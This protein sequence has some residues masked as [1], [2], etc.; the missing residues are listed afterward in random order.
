MAMQVTPVSIHPT[1]KTRAV[2]DLGV[3]SPYL[4]KTHCVRALNLKQNLNKT[5]FDLGHPFEMTLWVS[6]SLNF[7][8][9]GAQLPI[10]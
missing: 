4:R 10:K 9:L 8:Q 5:H 3:L 7:F 2:V 6:F 1:E